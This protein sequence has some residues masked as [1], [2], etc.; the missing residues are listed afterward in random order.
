MRH[1]FQ[2][3]DANGSPSQLPRL[4][5]ILARVKELRSNG[6]QPDLLLCRSERLLREEERKKISLFTNVDLRAVIS[7]CDMDN[8]YKIPLWLHKQG[9]MTS[10]LKKCI[11]ILNLRIYLTGNV[12]L[13]PWNTRSR[14]S[15][16]GWSVNMLI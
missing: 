14:K 15:P 8:I 13:M 1:P 6:I 3:I 16:L 5:T 7:A 11:W 12:L 4:E 2:V 9:W 10:L